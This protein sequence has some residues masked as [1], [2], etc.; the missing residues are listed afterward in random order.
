M[1][2]YFHLRCGDEEILDEVGIEAVSID[3]ARAEALK[4]A[5]ELRRENAALQNQW[6]GWQLQIVNEAGDVLSVIALNAI[7]HPIGG[8][9][10]TPSRDEDRSVDSSDSE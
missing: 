3:E 9:P 5:A 2:C 10:M 4:A 8:Q 1:R 6:N 7:M